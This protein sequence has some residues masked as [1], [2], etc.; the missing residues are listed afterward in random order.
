MGFDKRNLLINGQPIINKLEDELR[1][2]CP[3]VM[4]SCKKDDPVFLHIENL[5]DQFSVGGPLNG[6]MTALTTFPDDDILVVAADQPFILKNHL[7]QLIA[8]SDPT[9]P[10]ATFYNQSLKRPEPFPSL[11][12]PS[13]FKLIEFFLI[14]NRPSPLDFLSQTEISLLHTTDTRLHTN[15]NNPED[16]KGFLEISK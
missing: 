15:L 13:S 7:E 5:F 16:F 14:K 12:R 10:V 3:R 11:W 8:K 9:K 4:I 2:V 6:I 1:S